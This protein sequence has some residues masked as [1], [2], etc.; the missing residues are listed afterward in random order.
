[1]KDIV[2]LST[3]FN[4]PKDRQP[5]YFKKL[6][7]DNPNLDSKILRY[8]DEDYNIKDESYYF[9]FTF[10]RIRLFEKYL[11]ENILGKY[12]YF[13]LTDATDVGYVG[14]FSSWKE[15]L[16]FYQTDVLF[17]AEKFLWPNT[18]YSHLYNEK[19]ISSDFKYLNAGVV[20][21]NV[22]KYIKLCQRVL[23]RNLVGICDQG[24]WQIEYLLNK[25]IKIDHESKLVLN[26]F[27]AKNEYSV[28]EN[29]VTFNKTSP[30]FIHDN[31][32]YND[33]TVKLLKYFI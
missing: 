26:T 15:T 3:Y 11:K 7:E 18:D 13:L 5:V 31:G 30:I 33:S 14:G 22:K 1:M 8:W 24:N 20:L 10:Y 6:F 17:G 9:K 25:E 29:L 2:I 4:Y 23:E 19:N 27:N 16:N 32:G 12:E 21:A 28:K